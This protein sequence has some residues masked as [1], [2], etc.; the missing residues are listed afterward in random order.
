MKPVIHLNLPTQHITPTFLLHKIRKLGL[1]TQSKWLKG[2]VFGRGPCKVRFA[3]NWY[4]CFAFYDVAFKMF[5]INHS[6]WNDQP[7]SHTPFVDESI[8]QSEKLKDL[9]VDGLLKYSSYV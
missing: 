8:K 9:N 3:H 6:D 1:G 2:L 4:S 5:N 7:A